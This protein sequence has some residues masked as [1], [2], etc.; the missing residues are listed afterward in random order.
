MDQG[1]PIEHQIVAAIRQI[2]RAVDLHSRRLL[3]ACGL[4][5]PQ[6]ATLQVVGRLGPVSQID[7]ARAVHLSQGTVT[8]ILRRLESRGLI[9]RTRSHADRRSIEV[10]VTAD[11]QAVLASAPSLLQDEFRRE[12]ERLQIW[13]RHQ[14][15]STL[16]RVALL[17]HV[18]QI[19]AAPHLTTDA[20]GLQ[21]GDEEAPPEA[22]ARR[23][24]DGDAFPKF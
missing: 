10:E 6:L 8:G 7:I 12:L 4:T 18:E 19:D 11:G 22:H 24:S 1:L 2:V 14:I 3:E 5:G 17:M 20:V 21:S 16:Q 13:E 9:A 15:L 23:D